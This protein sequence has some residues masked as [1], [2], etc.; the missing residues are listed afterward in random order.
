MMFFLDLLIIL[1]GGAIIFLLF[2]KIHI[3]SLIGYLLLGIL[4]NALGL[5]DANIATIS[6]YLRKIALI[7]ILVKAGLSLDVSD[8]KKVGRPAIMMSFMPAVIEMVTV[9]LIAP[10]F[11]NITYVESFLLGSVLGAVSPAVVIPMM[12]RLIDEKRG[13]KKGIPQ[14]LL[15][16]SSIDDIIMIVFYQA[17]L[18]IESGGSINAMTFANIFIAII[19]G[20]VLGVGFGFLLGFIF[21]KVNIRNTLKI[22]IIIAIGIGMMAL[23]EFV[24]QYFGFSSLLAT[25]TMCVVLRIMNKENANELT[26]KTSK[27][28]IPAEM[29]LFFLV[30][31]SIKIEYASKFILPALAILG[32]SLVARS[33]MVSG[34]LIKTK[35]NWKERMFTVI[36]YLPKATV[37]ASIGGGLLDLG[38]KM[39]EV[40]NP[41]AD[42]II[43]AG[44]IVLSV[45]VLAILITAPISSL[46]MNLTYKKLLTD[47][48]ESQNS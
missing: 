45:S 17:F 26:K 9:G 27:I 6:P 37:Q 38:N 13:T 5:I 31:A 25:I 44:T 46:T 14:L 36:S 34:C 19:S 12:T 10:L 32:I 7:I 3:P 39:L 16:G 15:A 42:A 40:G 23:E 4:I 28:W 20:V 30:G 48:N 41:S 22:L 24:T 33:L 11:F 35:L 47:D 1:G 21:K 29:F 8:L 18:T 43:A 2:K